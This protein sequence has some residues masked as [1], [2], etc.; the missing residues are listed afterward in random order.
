[1]HSHKSIVLLR[2]EK[3]VPFFI[4][5][6]I[7]KFW[8]PVRPKA[9]KKKYKT[10]CVTTNEWN[11]IKNEYISNVKKGIKYTII[12]ENERITNKKNNELERTLDNIFGDKYI[13]V[14]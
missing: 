11:K 1:M 13:K 6:W 5:L 8:K 7:K 3:S 9:Y 12:D 14:D 4:S 10:V 2:R